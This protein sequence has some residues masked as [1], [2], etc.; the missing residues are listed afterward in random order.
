MYRIHTK[1]D[2]FYLKVTGELD[3]NNEIVSPSRV[4]TNKLNKL[5]LET[6]SDII[7]TTDIV[8]NTVI[9]VSKHLVPPKSGTSNYGIKI[10]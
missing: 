9:A 6:E 7:P 8:K 10:K 5:W 3:K 2:S 4:M 1:C